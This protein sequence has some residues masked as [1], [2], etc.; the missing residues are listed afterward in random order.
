MVEKMLYGRTT[1]E[2]ADRLRWNVVL[3]NS[4]SEVNHLFPFW[5]SARA[6]L[7]VLAAALSLPTPC[8][9]RNESF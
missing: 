5:T 7:S 9:L 6:P 2:L 4:S 3:F 1:G 8:L